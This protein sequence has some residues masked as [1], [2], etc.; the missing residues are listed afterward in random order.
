MQLI[1]QPAKAGMHWIKMGW[2]IYRKQPIVLT[3]LFL[4]YLFAVSVLTLIPVL[5]MLVPPLLLPG[6]TFGFFKAAE[7]T[8]LDKPIFPSLLIAGF[9]E[10]GKPFNQAQ[11]IE[12]LILGVFYLT[13]LSAILMLASLVDGGIMLNM[14]SS[15]EK[16]DLS[17]DQKVAMA[18]GLMVA[19]CLYIP[20]SLILWH[21]PALVVWEGQKAIKAVFFSAVACWRNKVP[22]MVY[23]VGWLTLLLS[24]PMSLSILFNLLFED[25][26]LI[27]ML[28]LPVLIVM[29]TVFVCTFYPMYKATFQE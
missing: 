1:E 3:T 8:I 29:N 20:L 28:V 16:I 13:G 24:I 2:M 14:M 4:S 27:R 10:P 17:D 19:I 9:Y 22:F 12:L 6:I 25:P 18:E 15:T 5:G 7:A 21:A 26:A 23:G 11:A